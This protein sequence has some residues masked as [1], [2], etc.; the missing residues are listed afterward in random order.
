MTESAVKYGILV[1]VDGSPESDAAVRWAAREAELRDLPIT[2]AHVVVPVVV[3]WPVRSFQADFDK[4]Q[5]DN[6]R[7]VIEQAQKRLT[8]LGQSEPSSVSTAVLHD[9][10]VPALV[11]AS[12]KAHLVA[13]GS[14]AWVRLAALCSARSAVVWYTMRAVPWRSSKPRKGIQLT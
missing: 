6:A 11:T 9:Y 1:G 7:Q 4:W 12:K 14:R 10:A 3:S 5:E 8:S 2:L 13:V